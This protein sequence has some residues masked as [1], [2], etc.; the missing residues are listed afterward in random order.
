HVGEPDAL[1]VVLAEDQPAGPGVAGGLEPPVLA[2]VGQPTAQPQVHLQA[3]VLGQDR[4]GGLGDPV[5]AETVTGIAT[6][7]VG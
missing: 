6:Y 4:T 5:M 2:Q 7:R 3:L 1:G